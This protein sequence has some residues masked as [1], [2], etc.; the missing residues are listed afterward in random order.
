MRRHRPPS[1]E[2]EAAMMKLHEEQLQL[3][4][5]NANKEEKI[6]SLK[7]LHEEAQAA[8]RRAEAE[9]NS[10]K[11]QLQ[12]TIRRISSE[13]QEAVVLAKYMRETLLKCKRD[14]SSSISP[15]KFAELIV[16]LE[17][18]RDSLKALQRKHDQVKASNSDLHLKLEKNR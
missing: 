12:D 6:Q 15:A 13:L 4:H 11:K 7:Q 2:H 14:A 10:E 9:H 18:T 1:E 16:Q 3:Q 5:E 17:T 8:F